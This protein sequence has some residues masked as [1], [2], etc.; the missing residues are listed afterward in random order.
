M[1]KVL[2]VIFFLFLVLNLYGKDMSL[3]VLDVGQGLCC[4]VIS[5]DDRCMVFDCGTV[6]NQQWKDNMAVFDKVLNPYLK[7]NH[8]KKI[9]YLV[10]SHPN[11]DHYSG[12]VGLLQKYPLVRYIKNGDT[13]NTI[14]YKLFQ[15]ELSKKMQKGLFVSTAKAGLTYKL[16]SSVSFTVLSPSYR[17]KT[18]NDN[19]LSVMVK[20]V[21][22]DVSFILTGDATQVAEKQTVKMFGENLKSQVLVVGHHGSHTSSSPEFLSKVRPKIAIISCGKKNSYGHPHRATLSILKRLKIKVY[23]TDQKG[24]VICKTNGKSITVQSKSNKKFKRR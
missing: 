6:T 14:V 19:D 18:D 4:V 11:F 1:R 9:D 20:V 12:L 16:G 7:S 23:R 24:S 22:K 5:P 10:L 21:Y 13:T 15:K 2:F 8:I 3:A 17:F